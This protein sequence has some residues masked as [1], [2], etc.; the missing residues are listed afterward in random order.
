MT[1]CYLTSLPREFM[2]ATADFDP[3]WPGSY[4]IPRATVLPPPALAAAVW[5]EIESWKARLESGEAEQN[6]AAGA[7]LE[8]LD[9]LRLVLLQDAPFLLAEYPEHPIF[10]SSV[11]H[12]LEFSIFAARVR[13]TSHDIQED[14]HSVAIE[15]AIPAVSEK[16]RTLA[17][18]LA[19]S[20][21][22]HIQRYQ[23]LLRQF[24]HVQ[25]QLD[26]L[27]RGSWTTYFSPYGRHT[28]QQFQH[29]TQQFQHTQT[30]PLQP[31]PQPQPQP[32]TPPLP[33]TLG[34]AVRSPLEPITLNSSH[35]PQ[36]L[37]RLPRD[38]KSVVELVQIWREG[39]AGMPSVTSL[40]QRWGSRWRPAS[41]K[42]FYCTR[43]I[44]IDE[45]ARRAAAKG[46]TEYEVA[47]QMDREKGPAS[48]DKV[49]KVIRSRQKQP[50]AAPL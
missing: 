43:K 48:L 8:L 15:K 34:Q 24:Q 41:E 18:Q 47:K 38:T 19:A 10:Q 7:F 44:I 33:Q 1:G 31:Q 25:R 28:T 35:Q 14:P 29:H 23:E 42:A 13:E 11:F 50:V 46:L 45:V 6:K 17:T 36:Q 16:L 26:D 49:M 5:P 20:E 22:F 40:E 9:W 39:V 32:S 12:S 30:S 3:E 21:R 2:R 27:T 4:Y 37:Y